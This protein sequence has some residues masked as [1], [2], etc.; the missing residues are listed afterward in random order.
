MAELFQGRN[1]IVD[2][3]IVSVVRGLPDTIEAVI[4][5]PA[6]AIR[7]TVLASEEQLAAGVIIT[8]VPE[9]DRREN[10]ALLSAR[11]WGWTELFL[12][13]GVSPGR[14]KLL[15]WDR[16]PDGAEQNAEFM[17]AYNDKGTE[18]V[19][20]LG[21]TFIGRAASKFKMKQPLQPMPAKPTLVDFFN[22]RFDEAQHTMQSATR[23]LKNG[24][25]ED[26]VF[27]CLLHDTGM[28]LQRRITATSGRPSM[29]PMWTKRSP[30]RS[31]TIRPCVFPGSRSRIRVSRD[32]L[33]DFGKD[34]VPEPY[35]QRDY[36]YARKHKWYMA[37]RLVTLNDEYSFDKSITLTIDPFIDIIGR[38]FKQPAK[39][40]AGTTRP[41]R[42]CGERSSIPRGPC[43]TS[44]TPVE[45]SAEFAMIWHSF[46]KSAN[47]SLREETSNGWKRS[48]LP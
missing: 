24:L 42:G 14:Y 38:N 17:D 33:R 30:G 11:S 48:H 25:P 34:F 43:S 8:L 32:V 21:S 20:T 37:A 2:R 44:V 35:I 23:A 5:S 28:A 22:L 40:S 1:S 31:V 4:Q 36:E 16:I 7:G 39:A 18:I 9:E 29:L 47:S 41:R 6:A 19:A 3:G 10:F 15:A 26:I 27:A 45:R 12:F 46:G 13:G